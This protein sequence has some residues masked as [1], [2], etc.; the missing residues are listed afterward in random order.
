MIAQPVLCVFW[1]GVAAYQRETTFGIAHGHREVVISPS[2][3]I[4]APTLQH[5]QNAVGRSLPDRSRIQFSAKRE[6]CFT[7]LQGEWPQRG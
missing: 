3:P 7:L 5:M 2:I 6:T 4:L 1:Q